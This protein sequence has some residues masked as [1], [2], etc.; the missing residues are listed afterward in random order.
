MHSNDS[1][2]SFDIEVVQRQ[3]MDN[4]VY[5]VQYAHAR[6]ASILAKAQREGVAQ[7]PVEEA[8]LSLLAHEAELDLLRTIAELPGRSRAAAE[9]RAPHRLS[10]AAQE[11]AARFHRFYTECRVVSDDAALTR[12]GC[13]WPP[14]RSRSIANLLDLMGVSAPE[15]MERTDG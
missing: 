13:G 10:L 3:S 7:K 11:L 8:D 2:M 15:L 14:A 12:R 5:Y 9:L 4:P 6:I 1:T